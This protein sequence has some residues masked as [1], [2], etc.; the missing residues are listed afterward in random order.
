ML[1]LGAHGHALYFSF[2]EA[3]LALLG[4]TGSQ[5][6]TLVGRLVLSPPLPPAL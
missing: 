5:G 3:E 1:A 2:S 6:K 4:L